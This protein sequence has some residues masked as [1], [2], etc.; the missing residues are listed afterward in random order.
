MLKVVPDYYK[1]F[2]CIGGSCKH[3]C[4]IGWEIDI[5]KETLDCYKAVKGKL[6]DKLKACIDEKP[7]PHFIL[8]NSERCPF[9]NKNNLCDI[10]IEEGENR[11][12]KICAEHPRFHNSLPGRTESGLG[13][14]CEEAARLIITKESPVRL[15][16][17]GVDDG[18]YDEIIA[19]RDEIIFLL[20]ERSLPL[21]I[22][23]NKAFALL[24]SDFALPS[25]KAFARL[26]M[27]LERLDESW[28]KILNFFLENY[29][30]EK[31]KKFA[32]FINSRLNEY[33]Q[34]SVYL[35]YRHLANSRDLPE[36]ELYLKF[37]AVVT[38]FIYCLGQTVF[39]KT[40]D[41]SLETQLEIIR[42]FSGEVE[43]SDENMEIIIDSLI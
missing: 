12:C 26:L 25:L 16:I 34:L 4:C 41:F 11:L 37:A 38:E 23:F 28:T 36:C 15:E 30:E 20:Q 6:Q 17:S 32:D 2:K 3:N 39:E 35:V 27:S 1:D 29:R 8:G 24:N 19:L 5:D 40:G 10:I 42:L 18:T 31:S 9:L 43:Y 14:V 13:L 7:T 33:E 22:R 21:E